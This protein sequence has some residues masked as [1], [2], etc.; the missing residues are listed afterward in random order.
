MVIK[1]TKR[2]LK[3]YGN[4]SEKIK[5][6]TKKALAFLEHDPSYPS[7]RI[8][9]VQ[10]EEG[11]WEARVDLFYRMVFTKKKEGSGESTIVLEDIGPHDKGL[12]KK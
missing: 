5:A 8:K 4:L 10:A 1:A 7:L 6:K 3:S 12:G 2:F 9:K 11:L